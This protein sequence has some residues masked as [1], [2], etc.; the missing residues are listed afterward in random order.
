MWDGHLMMILVQIC[1]EP[2]LPLKNR[3]NRHKWRN[4]RD[5]QKYH[6]C[7]VEGIQRPVLSIDHSRKLCQL[8]NLIIRLEIRSEL[9]TTQ[10]VQETL[11][12]RGC[13]CRIRVCLE[14]TVCKVSRRSEAESEVVNGD[15][16]VFQ[17]QF[18]N[19]SYCSSSTKTYYP[20]FHPTKCPPLISVPISAELQH[21]NLTKVKRLK[22]KKK[23]ILDIYYSSGQLMLKHQLGVR[24]IIFTWCLVVI[25]LNI[26]LN[27][28]IKLILARIFQGHIK[29][30]SNG[31]CHWLSTCLGF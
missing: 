21:N 27:L 4:T 8:P 30:K 10:I 28:Q 24:C 11:S 17:F 22:Q 16:G 3:S 18:P 23:Y 20:Y 13:S 14:M 26:T 29:S 31:S 6:Q 1:L 5:D 7:L 9:Q 19:P 2:D 12:R 15:A 25:W